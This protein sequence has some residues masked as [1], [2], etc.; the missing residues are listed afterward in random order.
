MRPSCAL[1]AALAIATVKR[2]TADAAYACVMDD[3]HTTKLAQTMAWRSCDV[4]D[5]G[6]DGGLRS[7][8]NMQHR[9]I[10]S[11]VT[12]TKVAFQ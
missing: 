5:R 4:K 3:A 8:V 7:G 2:Y 1:S 6:L 9:P 10:A 11:W 12:T